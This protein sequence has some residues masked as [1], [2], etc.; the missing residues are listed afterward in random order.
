MYQEH[1]Q[2]ETDH[3]KQGV[4]LNRQLEK[5]KE[6]LKE[7]RLDLAKTI[8]ELDKKK[9]AFSTEKTWVVERAKQLA[10]AAKEQL[11]NEE[12]ERAMYEL[13][14]LQDTY[15]KKVVDYES[16]AQAAATII[17]RLRQEKQEAHAHAQLGVDRIQLIMS[18]WMD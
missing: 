14:K 2:V 6:Q 11:G 9:E 12:A 17:V 7:T 5:V 16:Q 8:D 13:N 10:K 15:Q 18:A 1:K 4:E 3:K